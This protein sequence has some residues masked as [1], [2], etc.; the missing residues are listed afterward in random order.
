LHQS[1]PSRPSA[2]LGLAGNA[3][4]IYG[5][6]RVSTDAQDFTMWFSAGLSVPRDTQALVRAFHSIEAVDPRVAMQAGKPRD[7][8]TYHWIVTRP[9][10]HPQNFN[11]FDK[12]VSHL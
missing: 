10:S 4:M 12:K 2:P 6:T 1:Y 8:L 3:G 11:I 9:S 5:Y 7:S